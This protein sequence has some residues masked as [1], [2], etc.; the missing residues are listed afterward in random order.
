MY[1]F[2]IGMLKNSMQKYFFFDRFNL[3]FMQGFLSSSLFNFLYEPVALFGRKLEK[4]F[5]TEEE[6]IFKRV[7]RFLFGGIIHYIQNVHEF[8]SVVGKQ[9][10]IFFPP[11]IFLTS[12]ILNG[13]CWCMVCMVQAYCLSEMSCFTRSL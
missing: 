10:T 13:P 7:R 2:L 6:N 8:D 4:C 1:W 11:H 5:L 3:N 9:E 12:N